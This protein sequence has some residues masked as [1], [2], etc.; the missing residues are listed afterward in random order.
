MSPNNDKHKIMK[1]FLLTTFIVLFSTLTLG[2]QNALNFDGTDDYI[3]I[4]NGGGLNNLQTGTIE[5]WVKWIGNNQDVGYGNVYGAVLARQNNNDFSNQIIALSATNPDNAKIV[6]CPYTN[7]GRALVSSSSPISDTWVH[8]AIV[9]EPGKHTMY[10]NGVQEATSAATGN[11]HDDSSVPLSIGAWIGH[12]NSYSK[13][14]ID[15]VRIWD[16]IRTQDEINDNRNTELTGNE[17][18]LVSYYGFNQ[19]I[20]GGNNPGENTLT[21]A[22]SNSNNGTLNNFALIGEF[23]NWVNGVGLATSSASLQI[24]NNLSVHP[25]PSNAFIQI[26]GLT[27][28]KHFTIYDMLGN[29]IYDGITGNNEA[30]D[31]RPLTNGMYFLKLENR[32]PIKFIKK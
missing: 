29:A 20:A 19:G 12:G 25:N 14:E 2:A 11:M 27:R 32:N 31:I 13:A 17:S 8:I 10:V 23:S 5:M 18:N 28:A 3:A 21:D 1:H 6:W 24:E 7:S 15:E 4:P 30:I 22:T 9:Y 16:D 26:T